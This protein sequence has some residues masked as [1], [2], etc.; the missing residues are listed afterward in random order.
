LAIIK[1]SLA[2]EMEEFVHQSLLALRADQR[3]PIQETARTVRAKIQ[4]PLKERTIM[5]IGQISV[6]LLHSPSVRH[7]INEKNS[8]S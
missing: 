8:D 2:E 7:S 1:S 3:L 5:I 6:V 4:Y